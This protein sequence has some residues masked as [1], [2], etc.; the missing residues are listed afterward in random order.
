MNIGKRTPWRPATKG[1]AVLALALLAAPAHGRTLGELEF[2]PC[3][4]TAAGL[5]RPTEAQCATVAVPENPAEP[6]GRSIELALAWIPVEGEA[7]PDP[8]FMIAGGPG[9][10]A[11][12]SYPM[13][14]SAFSDV[15]RSRHIMLLDQRG[16]G[17]SNP[18][19]CDMP[20]DEDDMPG[21]DEF[22]P[23]RARELAETC[24]DELAEQADLRFYSTAEAV[25][26][27]DV[28]RRAI[29]AEQVNLVGVSY[30]TRVAQLYAKTYP[31]HVRTLVLDGVVPMTLALGAEHATNLQAAL[32][33]Q[34]ARCRDTPACAEALGDP[35]ARLDEVAAR[36]RDGGL[37]PVRYRDPT[38]G[39]WR[40]ETPTYDHFA[41]VLRMYA[42]QPLSAALLPL[43]VHQADEGDYA[44]LLAMVRMMMRDIGGQMATGM[45]NSVICT[46]DADELEAQ[47]DAAD[48]TL[49]GADFVAFLEATCEAWP[50]G[51]RPA[52]FRA[53]L[54]GEMPVLLVSGEFDPVTPP[55]YGDAVA[56]HLANAR[57]LVLREQGH[58]LL[59]SGCMPKLLAQFIEGADPA[60]LDAA[61]LDRLAAPPPFSGL[62][63]WEP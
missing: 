54:E 42:Y 17:E 60:A 53:P 56:N 50:R 25:F 63:G 49:L 39:E 55:R 52:D 1:V 20:D 3:V 51:Q 12:D 38:S 23:E 2:E 61:C 32:D 62:Y 58:S 59:T 46:E 30:G 7:E 44:A 37:E 6:E 31:G 8:V 41:G 18:L 11:R 35:R 9:Q 22:S 26:D 47:L 33:A 43:I 5:P 29:G 36:L 28:V 14:S 24:R 27:L 48:G 34:F 10:S 4:L 57:H 16:T 21:F 13:V 19:V 40:A 15:R 45:H